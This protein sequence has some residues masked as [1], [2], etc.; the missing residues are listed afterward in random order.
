MAIFKPSSLV[1]GISGNVGGINFSAGKNGN[2]I[3]KHRRI[4]PALGER[5]LIRQALF[6]EAARRWTFILTDTQ[7]REWAAIAK[8]VFIRNR[9]GERRQMSGRTLYIRQVASGRDLI[10]SLD[11]PGTLFNPNNF[12]GIG[13]TANVGGPFTWTCKKSP[14]NFV[15]N[16][17]L[18]F[19]RPFTD[20]HVNTAHRWRR[21]SFTLNR[22]PAPG[23]DVD[24]FSQF[25]EQWG[26]PNVGERIAIRW[27][28]GGTGEQFP[29]SSG[30]IFRTVIA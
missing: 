2:I 26:S 17:K 16:Y 11:S 22:L 8:D 28:A 12:S 18:D 13:L 21:Q 24:I 29:G 23:F 25:E 19:A 10:T 4:T 3:R 15:L 1:E 30:Q 14:S 20:S 7:R 27:V 6:N 5:Q 9:L